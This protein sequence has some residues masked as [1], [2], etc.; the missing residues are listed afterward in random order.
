[1]RISGSSL[2]RGVVA[3]VVDRVILDAVEVWLSPTGRL[4]P[5][6]LSVRELSG[7]LVPFTGA[8]VFTVI[9]AAPA[10]I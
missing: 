3:V 8:E 5:S 7:T 10:G 4:D 2:A 1:M 6:W 9:S